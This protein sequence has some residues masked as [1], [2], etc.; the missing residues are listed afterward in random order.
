[1]KRKYDAILL[2]GLK[3]T[4]DGRPVQELT[5]RI[6]KAAECYHKGLSDLIIPCGGQTPGT[7]VSE[8]AVM[9]DALRRL[10]VPE[11]A[12]LCE[13]Q[14]Q[15]TVENIRNARKL[16]P[17]DKPRV[18]VVTSDYHTLRACMI[19]RREAQMRAKGCKARIPWR[20]KRVAAILEP[21]HTIDFILGYQCTGK[22]RPALYLKIMYFLM[23]SVKNKYT[24]VS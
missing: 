15:Y 14:S 22:K 21:L 5:L 2:L 1:M 8:A 4:P 18:L 12:I 16:L 6:E 13:N 3:L 7:P 17:G 24:P 9:K 20:I 10:N 19:C 11:S 23:D